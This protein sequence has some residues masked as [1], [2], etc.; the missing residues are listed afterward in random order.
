MDANERIS[1]IT[2]LM[3]S[4]F[5][6]KPK[7]QVG[8]YQRPYLAW[9]DIVQL[10]PC[11]RVSNFSKFTGIEDMTSMEHMS[12]YLIQLGEASIEEAHRV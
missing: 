5:G 10:P 12:R 11:Y 1:R 7:N 9:Y 6:L 2:T 8:T 4:Q 3:Q